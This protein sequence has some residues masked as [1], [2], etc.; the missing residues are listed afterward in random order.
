MNYSQNIWENLFVTINPPNSKKSLIIGNIYR[1]PRDRSEF[2][3]TFKNEFSSII[4]SFSCYE[5]LYVAGDYNLD[6]LRCDS[7][8]AISDF[9]ISFALS[10]PFLK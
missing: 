3:V 9:F 4:E 6:L 2:L 7:S 10:A 1:P 8:T 5:Q